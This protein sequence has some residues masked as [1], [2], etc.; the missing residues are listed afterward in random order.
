MIQ[1][2][3]SGDEQECHLWFSES[4]YAQPEWRARDRSR[5][6]SLFSSC[7][8]LGMKGSAN[9][10]AFQDS[11]WS[12]TLCDSEH[13]A[14]NLFRGQDEIRQGKPQQRGQRFAKGIKDAVESGLRPHSVQR[15]E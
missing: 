12:A 3:T 13:G 1:T 15:A 8:R 11:L 6:S 14:A 7:V 10:P 2:T 9:I 4:E 5:G